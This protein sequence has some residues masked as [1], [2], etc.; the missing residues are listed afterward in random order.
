MPLT[1]GFEKASPYGRVIHFGIR[2]HAMGA[3]LNGIA[4]NGLSKAYAGTLENGNLAYAA[5]AFN[6]GEACT[7]L[8]GFEKGYDAWH[9]VLTTRGATFMQDTTNP[10]VS[11]NL[12]FVFRFSNDSR[13]TI[14]FCT[15]SINEF[16]T[17]FL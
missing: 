3:I 5:S 2:E 7:Y 11:V 15:E 6:T 9:F 17:I 12:N 4:L 1:S 14:Y 8:P 13:T 16:R 10:A